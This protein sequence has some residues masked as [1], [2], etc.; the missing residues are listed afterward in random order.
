MKVL[1]KLLIPAMLAFTGIAQGQVI[2]EEQRLSTDLQIQSRVMDRLATLTRIEGRIGVESRDA[3]VTLSGWT[4]T[5]AEAGI[6]EAEARKVPGVASVHN[7]I[8]PR[9]S[10]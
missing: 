7:A 3:V 5:T 6:A 2:V 9:M 1:N 8:R 10:A 4:R